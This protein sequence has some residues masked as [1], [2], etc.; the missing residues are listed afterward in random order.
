M[1]EFSHLVQ[2]IDSKVDSLIQRCDRLKDANAKL[3]KDNA[4]LSVQLEGKQE[5]IEALNTKN[6]MLKVAGAL[7]GDGAEQSEAKQKINEL[8][9]EIDK[10]IALLNR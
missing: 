3:D 8:V 7:S 1:P 6:K 9:R 4:A 2:T 5:E 10:C